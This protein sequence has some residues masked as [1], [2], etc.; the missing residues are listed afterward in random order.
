MKVLMK[1]HQSKMILKKKFNEN[2]TNELFFFLKT[3]KEKK[4]DIKQ[5]RQRSGPWCDDWFL[6]NHL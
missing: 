4:N 6:S 1:A 2:E 5:T 3:N